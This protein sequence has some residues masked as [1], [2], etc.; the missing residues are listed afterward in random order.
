MATAIGGSSEPTF[1]KANGVPEVCIRTLHRVTVDDLGDPNGPLL[2]D[3]NV[4]GTVYHIHDKVEAASDKFTVLFMNDQG[5]LLQQI[6]GLSFGETP[7]YTGAT[8]EKEHP[9]MGVTYTF[10]GWTPAVTPC[11]GDPATDIVY[12]AKYKSTANTFTVVFRQ[13]KDGVYTTLKTEEVPYNTA[14]HAPNKPS[15]TGYTAGEWEA[16]GDTT[17]RSYG[18]DFSTILENTTITV[19]LTKKQYEVKFIDHDDTVLKTEMVEHGGNATA[20]ANPTWTGHTFSKWDKSFANV[21]SNLIVNAVYTSTMC[22]VTFVDG[23]GTT[24]LEVECDYGT[25][26]AGIKPDETPTHEGYAFTNWDKADSFIITENTV[27]T[28]QWEEDRFRFEKRVGWLSAMKPREEMEIHVTLPANRKYRLTVTGIHICNSLS[29]NRYFGV[30]VACSS[31]IWNKTTPSE[32]DASKKKLFSTYFNDYVY[33]SVL[34]GDKAVTLKGNIDSYDTGFSQYV[35]SN[36]VIGKTYADLTDAEKAECSRFVAESEV[37]GEDTALTFTCF[38][39]YNGVVYSDIRIAG[40]HG[41]YAEAY[42]IIES[43]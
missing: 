4:N 30:Q 26:V 5:T 18:S 33:T 36:A 16:I 38:P 21:T 27:I 17:G 22:T 1:V 6:T 2:A 12:T 20:P 11:S 23:F 14:A 3:I 25:T 39:S 31:D 35:A 13:L 29:P 42:V 7:R 19:Q 34:G 41:F 15:V 8:P 32:A 9:L 43:I 10:D 24:V 40:D 28:A 37:L